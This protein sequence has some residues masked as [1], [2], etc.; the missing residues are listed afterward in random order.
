MLTHTKISNILYTL[1]ILYQ[2]NTLSTEKIYC[3]TFINETMALL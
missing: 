1:Y 2:Q 3:K